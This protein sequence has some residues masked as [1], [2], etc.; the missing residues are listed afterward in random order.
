[1]KRARAR[2]V[3]RNGRAVWR[4]IIPK[5]LAGGKVG[6]ARYFNSRELAGDFVATLEAG[7]GTTTAEVAGLS[8]AD[9]AAVLHA[10]ELVGK[11]AADLVTAAEFW[12][13]HRPQHAGKPLAEA[14]EECLAAKGAANCRERYVRGLRGTLHRFRDAHPGAE[15]AKVTTL[16][17]ARWLD[18]HAH[19][20]LGTRKDG[21][22]NLR[23]FFE[24]CRARGYTAGNPAKGIARPTVDHGTPAVLSVADGRR[25]L[26][27]ALATDAGL[28]P[29]LA[30]VMFGGLRP[31]E[32]AHV[33]ASAVHADEGT[34]EVAASIAKNRRR[35][36]VE[37][38]ATLG[39]W[40]AVAGG[41][42]QPTNLERR[43]K[44][45]RA[46]AADASGPLAWPH[47]GLRHSFCSYGYAVKGPGWVCVQAD[48]SEA[49]L[50]KHYRATVT[51]AAAEAW[52]TLT[53][54]TV[55]ATPA[56]V[57]AMPAAPAAAPAAAVA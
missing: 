1:M 35:R 28:V 2:R 7:R 18:G 32:A 33:P 40:L 19:W 45:V 24:F 29:Y 27:A 50:R 55:D 57:V 44:R 10:L 38:N 48:H 22:V 9:L 16:E 23:T 6:S 49:I 5:A 34:V 14:V 43:L 47:D 37:L 12:R 56:N 51:R 52:W 11:Q 3:T 21:V 31:D 4:V 36:L 15:V 54:A 46:A 30:L 53:P 8:K 42:F 25:L 17:L 20:S 41:E 13:T 39:A 26:A